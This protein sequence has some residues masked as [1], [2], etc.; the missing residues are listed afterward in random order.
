[1]DAIDVLLLG[2]YPYRNNVSFIRITDIL[3]D[4]IYANTWRTIARNAREHGYIEYPEN[5]EYHTL[6]KISDFGIQYV[7]KKYADAEKL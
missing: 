3:S 4:S 1:M 7:E 6:A 5:S 2:L